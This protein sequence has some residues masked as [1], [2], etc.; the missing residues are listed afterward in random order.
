VESTIFEN[1][2]AKSKAVAQNWSEVKK[3][4]FTADDLLDAYTSGKEEHHRILKKAF[5]SNISAV[6]D[7]SDALLST[8]SKNNIS[9][10]RA[11]IKPEGLET[12]SA[13][14]FVPEKDALSKAFDKI[15]KEA[16]K[17]RGKAENNDLYVDFAFVPFTD[18]IDEDMVNADG[19]TIKYIGKKHVK[20]AR[21][22]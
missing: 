11:F 21:T 19:Y 14:F 7:L 20:A 5:Q 17:I 4:S 2:A 15:Y 3:D 12:F 18:Y 9:C 1:I 22:A 10:T 13:L 16:E 8:L 6:I